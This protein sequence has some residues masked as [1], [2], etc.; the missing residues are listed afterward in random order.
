MECDII[1]Y[2]IIEDPDEIAEAVWVITGKCPNYALSWKVISVCSQIQV[3]DVLILH[4]F[5]IITKFQ[6]FV[7]SFIDREKTVSGFKA[8]KD[9]LPLLVGDLTASDCKLTSMYFY[10]SEN[11]R[12]FESSFPIYF[13]AN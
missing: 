8:A 12:T 13:K 9:R 7:N 6:T 1:I 3:L 5:S 10:L 2:D 4:K 11:L